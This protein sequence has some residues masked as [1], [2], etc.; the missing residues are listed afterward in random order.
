MLPTLLAPRLVL[1]PLQAADAPAMQRYASDFDVARMLAQVPHPY[2]EGEA[3]AFIA[4]VCE[5]DDDLPFRVFAIDQDGFAGTAALAADGD[6]FA[7]RTGRLGYWLGRPFWGHGL[8]TEAVR[9]LLADYAFGT[10][11]LRRVTAGV[12]DDN[13]AS[14]RVLAKLGF[15]QT[16]EEMRWSEARGVEVRHLLY[17]VTPVAFV[18]ALR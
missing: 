3:A 1:R 5:L 6:S 14:M 9:V 15:T 10:L 7:Q 2:P 17:A 8:A 11:G 4:E 12:F 16:G 13:P 18:E